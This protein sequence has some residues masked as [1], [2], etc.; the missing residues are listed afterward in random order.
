ML[1]RRLTNQST[2]N[3]WSANQSPGSSMGLK[4]IFLTDIFS[5]PSPITNKGGADSVRFPSNPGLTSAPSI[6][7]KSSMVI[8]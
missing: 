6:K 3:W 7:G 5:L 1:A 2:E 8:G 4:N